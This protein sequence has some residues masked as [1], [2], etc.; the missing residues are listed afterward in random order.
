MSERHQEDVAGASD[1]ALE[2][3]LDT[4]LEDSEIDFER[5]ADVGH[6]VLV[7][8]SE[9]FE[10]YDGVV[11]LGAQTQGEKVAIQGVTR[12]FNEG[13]E[14]VDGLRTAIAEVAA[15]AG[16]TVGELQAA[17][18]RNLEREAQE[19]ETINEATVNGGESA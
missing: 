5:V 18:E 14:H 11:V 15:D 16:V 17:I 13:A 7:E 2:A 10:Y 8:E 4:R 19:N 3:D 12:Q 6:D 9:L 1:H